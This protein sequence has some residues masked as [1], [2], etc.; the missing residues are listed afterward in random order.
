MFF[1]SSQ[2][3][4]LIDKEEEEEQQQVLQ[5]SSGGPRQHAPSTDACPRDQKEAKK[6]S[7]YSIWR[8]E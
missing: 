2:L 4:M 8:G 7:T 3:A 5:V 1:I 6:G